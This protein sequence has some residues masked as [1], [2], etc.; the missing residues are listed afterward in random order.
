MLMFSVFLE[1]VTM[2]RAIKI[3]IIINRKSGNS[4][5]SVIIK[6]HTSIYVWVKN[7]YLIMQDRKPLNNDDYCGKVS[8]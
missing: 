3:A 7:D 8:Y 4:T 6:H 1:T 2:K 5:L